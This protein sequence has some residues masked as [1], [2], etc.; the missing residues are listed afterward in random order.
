MLVMSVHSY[1]GGTGKTLLSTNLAASYARK[2]KVCLMDYD[3]RAP[4][5]HSLFDI[6]MPDWWIN[7][8]L[9]GDCEIDEVITEVLPNLYVGLANPDAEAIREMM[10]KGRSWET[11]ALSKTIQ[12]REALDKLGFGK[13]IFDTA[14]GLAYSSINAVV[15]SDVVALVMRMD[16]LDILGTK[17]MVKG[18]YELLEKPTYFVVNMVLPEQVEAHFALLQ[19]TFGDKTAAYLPCL[20]EVR[21]LLAKGKTILIDEGL[22]YS[23]ALIGLAR[24]LEAATK[25]LA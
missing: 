4:S 3:L 10:G 13:I 20:C 18:V 22:G 24:D 2:E 7:D 15:G 1:R 6:E 9:N 12:M 21:A 8:Y 17:E 5:L 16:A 25:E 19:S 11:Q 14:P 23:E